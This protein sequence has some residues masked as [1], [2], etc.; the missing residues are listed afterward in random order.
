MLAHGFQERSGNLESRSIAY[1]TVN[2][3]PWA[4]S[5]LPITGRVFVD[6]LKYRTWKE[7][8][9]TVEAA[10][11]LAPDDLRAMVA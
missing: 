2:A 10:T 4:E 1:D 5:G 6:P 8:H 9:T 3:A 11:L 7:C